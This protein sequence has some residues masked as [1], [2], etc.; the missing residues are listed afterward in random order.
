MYTNQQWI[1]LNADSDSVD[2]EWDLGCFT[3]NRFSGSVNVAILKTYTWAQVSTFLTRIKH[4]SGTGEKHC[5]VVWAQVYIGN[6]WIQIST[7]SFHNQLKLC[8]RQHAHLQWITEFSEKLFLLFHRLFVPEFRQWLG[9][10]YRTEL[11]LAVTGL[12]ELSGGEGASN[13]HPHPEVSQLWTATVLSHKY[14]RHSQVC[15]MQKA[16]LPSQEAPQSHLK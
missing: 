3:H 12:P 9:K 11:R 16:C 6:I 10:Q 8:L 1:L 13:P 2:L 7:Q 4:D 14:S 5:T 15:L